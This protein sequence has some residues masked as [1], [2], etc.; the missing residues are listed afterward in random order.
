M[1]FVLQSWSSFFI[2]FLIHLK[3]FRQRGELLHIA[4]ALG[5]ELQLILPTK[6]VFLTFRHHLAGHE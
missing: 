3:G 5:G 6:A 1:N 4:I 2:S